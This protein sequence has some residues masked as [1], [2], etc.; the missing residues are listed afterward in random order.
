[1]KVVLSVAENWYRNYVVEIPDNLS[2]AE[3]DDAAIAKYT[4]WLEAGMPDSGN[5]FQLGEPEY[6]DEGPK[7]SCLVMRKFEE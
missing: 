4:A 3:W 7:E 6:L 2:P 1:M 5:I